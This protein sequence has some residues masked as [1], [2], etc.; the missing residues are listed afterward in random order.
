MGKRERERMPSEVR[1]GKGLSNP[2]E[3]DLQQCEP[4]EE[5]A[6]PLSGPL[7][8]FTLLTAKTFLEPQ[9]VLFCF[10]N[11]SSSYIDN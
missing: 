11:L 6:G 9:D 7:Q 8:K 1:R 10:F 4:P 3:L 2:L 5:R